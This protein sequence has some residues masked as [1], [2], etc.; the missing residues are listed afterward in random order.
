MMPE[1]VDICLSETCYLMV[2]LKGTLSVAVI[3]GLGQGSIMHSSIVLDLRNRVLQV[4]ED[5]LPFGVIEHGNVHSA[6]PAIEQ[7]RH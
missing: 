1:S 7:L 5:L 4:R 2:P 3:F 6:S